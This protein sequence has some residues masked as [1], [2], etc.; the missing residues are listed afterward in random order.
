MVLNWKNMKRWVTPCALVLGMHSTFSPVVFASETNASETNASEK[1]AIET[2]AIEKDVLDK[3]LEKV[4]KEMLKKESEWCVIRYDESITPGKPFK[5]KI[6]MRESKKDLKM[7]SALHWFD[8][9]KKYGGVLKSFKAIKNPEAN[10]D[11]VQEKT[12][13]FLPEN[14]SF[15]VVV[16]HLSP[17]GGWKDRVAKLSSTRIPLAAGS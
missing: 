10:Q 2:S 13:H 16:S 5:F 1:D 12:F 9:N 14:A 3:E 6:Y 17:T 11:Y 8:Q 7:I 15:F 4:E